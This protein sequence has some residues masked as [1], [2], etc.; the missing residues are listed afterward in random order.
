VFRQ[1]YYRHDNWLVQETTTDGLIGTSMAW[2]CGDRRTYPRSYGNKA[3]RMAAI[4]RTV[5]NSGAS[6][7]S[8]DGTYT[9]LGVLLVHSPWPRATPPVGS[10]ALKANASARTGLVE[11][12][13]ES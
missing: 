9:A 7:A 1:S 8:I 6:R 2:Y 4:V 3:D 10:H 11:A 12:A 13:V 5:P